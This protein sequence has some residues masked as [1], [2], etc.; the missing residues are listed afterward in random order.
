[1]RIY[2]RI[3]QYLSAGFCLAIIIGAGSVAT[4]SG[5]GV[6]QEVLRRMD[7]NYSSLNSLKCSVKMDKTDAAIGET[8]T[9]KGAANYLPKNASRK[10][11][12][13]IDWVSPEEN[14][15][16]I[17]EDYKIYRKALNQLIVGKTSGT[18][19]KGTAGNALAFVSMSKAQLQANYTV[20]YAGEEVIP[21]AIKT[22]H[23]VLT[24]KKASSYKTAEL[25]VDQ[26]GMPRQ[27]RITENNNDT[28]VVLL[29]DL[30]KNAVIDASVFALNPKGAK[31]VKA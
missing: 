30:Q 27:A 16:V 9:T 13:R 1:M 26:N 23:L 21:G 14:M 24:P 18:K 6:L 19:T 11:Y 29:S 22:W 17:G 28:T 20:Q 4:A 5:Q 10:M 31:I 2:S 15:V 7:G 8:D 25:W 3:I 12:V